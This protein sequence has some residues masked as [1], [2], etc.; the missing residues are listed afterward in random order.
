[1]ST[2]IIIEYSLL[3]GAIAVLLLIKGFVLNRKVNKDI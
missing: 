2:E 1:M 3:F